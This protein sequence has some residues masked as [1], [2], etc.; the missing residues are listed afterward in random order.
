[1]DGPEGETHPELGAQIME[2]FGESWADFT[3]YHSKVYA[4]R[5]RV[6]YS[7]LCVADKL[8]VSL[9][10]GWFY[11]PR[12]KWSGEIYE[13]MSMAIEGLEN[14]TPFNDY[15][16]L[17]I[18]INDPLCWHWGI[19]SYMHRWAYEHKDCKPDKWTPENK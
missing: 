2:M 3:R 5:N 18:K 4:K 13:Y 16:A 11:L 6:H 19:Q 9:E 7:R 17:L 8:A 10:P 12:I 14:G 15:E 1:M